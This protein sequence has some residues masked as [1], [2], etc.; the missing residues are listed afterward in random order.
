L[1]GEVDAVVMAAVLCP[2]P[3]PLPLLVLLGV[4][5][6]LLLL[7]AGLGVVVVVVVAD[8]PELAEPGA[9]GPAAARLL[10][11]PGSWLPVGGAEAAY[12]GP[13]PTRPL[14]MVVGIAY[15]L[16]PHTK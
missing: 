7:D 4:V 10:R 2:L 14:A 13:R 12:S 16:P 9:L 1:G 11:G 15:R 8:D 5:L 3:L 6:A